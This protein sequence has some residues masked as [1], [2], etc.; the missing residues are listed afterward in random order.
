MKWSFKIE[1]LL[2][3]RTTQYTR[4]FTHKML[5]LFTQN[6]RKIINN[7]NTEGSKHYLFEVFLLHF[8]NVKV[9]FYKLYV[10]SFIIQSRNKNIHTMKRLLNKHK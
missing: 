3:K 6:N 2:I 7:I 10:E 9:F 4:I 5:R 1:F 8:C